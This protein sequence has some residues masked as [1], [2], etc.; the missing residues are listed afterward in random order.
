MNTRVLF[1]CSANGDRSPTAEAIYKQYPGLETRSTGIFKPDKTVYA[2]LRWAN[3]IVAMEQHHAEYIRKHFAKAL[4]EKP[5]YTLDI[6][7]DYLYMQDVLIQF[8]HERMN[9]ILA[10]ILH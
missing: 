5:L 3:V 8:I 9:A 4:A 1:I 6:P 2:C 10:E 7:D